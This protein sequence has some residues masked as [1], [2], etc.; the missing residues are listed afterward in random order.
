MRGKAKERSTEK[1]PE[2]RLENQA[3]RVIRRF[4]GARNL[5]RALLDIGIK[6]SPS[7][8]YKWTYPKER[9]GTDGI[10]PTAQ[11]KQICEA[12]RIQ[13][14]LLTSEDLDPRPIPIANPYMDPHWRRTNRKKLIAGVKIK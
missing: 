11:M 6:Q 7:S 14:I 3:E 1:P 9:S 2:S 10:I 8:I 5:A 13:G 4:G 12:A